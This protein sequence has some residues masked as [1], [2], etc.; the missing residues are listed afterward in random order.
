[1]S[2]NTSAMEGG[3]TLL[4]SMIED[5]DPKREAKFRVTK[6]AALL[7]ALA[8]AHAQQEHYVKAIMSMEDERIN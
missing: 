3:I 5:N 2:I 6:R 7:T 4:L 1:M 8:A